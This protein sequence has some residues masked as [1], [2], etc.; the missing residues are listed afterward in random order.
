MLT[1]RQCVVSRGLAL[2]ASGDSAGYAAPLSYRALTGV[3][4]LVMGLIVL[5]VVMLVVGVAL[6]PSDEPYKETLASG[7]ILFDERKFSTESWRN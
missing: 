5:I 6:A 2:R 1:C 4:Q 7:I 3:D